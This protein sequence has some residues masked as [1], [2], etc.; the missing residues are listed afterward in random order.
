MSLWRG[1][2]RYNPVRGSVRSWVLSVVRH[3]A[4]DVFRGEAVRTRHNV[5]DEG[6]AECLP[7]SDRTDVEVER[8]DDAEEVRAALR[9]LPA[10]Q[11][12]V[13]E[14]AYF[15]D[16]THSQIADML[17]LPAGTVRGRM[18]LGVTKLRISLRAPVEAVL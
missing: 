5:S 4:I 6:V 17:S 1:G 14:L 12:R 16:F 18:R 3:R 9:E 10:D 2:G 13:L 8:R 11:R 15:G 7:A